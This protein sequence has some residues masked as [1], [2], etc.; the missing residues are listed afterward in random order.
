VE[1]GARLKTFVRRSRSERRGPDRFPAIS[2]RQPNADRIIRGEKS[3]DSRSRPT[4]FRGWILLH[5]SQTFHR[6]DAARPGD[7][8]LERGKILGLAQLADCVQNGDGWTYMW[9]N[10]RRFHTPIPCRGHYSI[11]F[12]VPASLVAGTPAARVTPGKL[13]D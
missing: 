2:L 10:P 5:A 8:D 11:P 13:E 6:D 7:A 4:R 9:K 12:Y 3:R 1:K